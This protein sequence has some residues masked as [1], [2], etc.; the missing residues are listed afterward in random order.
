MCCSS[1]VCLY[2]C[3]T[4]PSLLHLVSCCSLK[5]LYRKALCLLACLSL[6]QQ[7]WCVGL[8]NQSLMSC[9]VLQYD[10]CASCVA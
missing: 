5:P 1:L 4:G 9:A 3:L 10:A 7:T 8:I 6:L 2:V